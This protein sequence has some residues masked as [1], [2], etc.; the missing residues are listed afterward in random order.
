MKYAIISKNEYCVNSPNSF[1]VVCC[2]DANG[3]T[4]QPDW[5]KWT[6]NQ[7]NAYVVPVAEFKKEVLGGDSCWSDFD[8]ST[9]P[10]TA[11]FCK[12]GDEVEF[13]TTYQEAAEACWVDC[14]ADWKYSFYTV[15]EAQDEL[16][17]KPELVK[18]YASWV[19]DQIIEDGRYNFTELDFYKWVRDTRKAGSEVSALALIAL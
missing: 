16:L 7:N 9:I 11:K 1:S 8:L 19:E 6:K 12:I 3:K 4:I 14:P 17:N 5:E 15:A 13:Y 10:D 2:E 18:A